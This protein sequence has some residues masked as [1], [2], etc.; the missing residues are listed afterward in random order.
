MLMEISHLTMEERLNLWK[1]RKKNAAGEGQSP[2]AGIISA[3]TT[4]NKAIAKTTPI[5]VPNAKLMRKRNRK[6]INSALSTPQPTTPH[7]QHNNP[8][9]NKNFEIQKRTKKENDDPNFSVEG[10]LCS[11]T[12]P[13]SSDCTEV[14]LIDGGIRDMCLEADAKQ[15]EQQLPSDS[16]TTPPQQTSP[17]LSSSS[18]SH[19]EMQKLREK[20]AELIK[21]VNIA[22]HER[23]EAFKIAKMSVAENAALQ[24]ENDIMNQ[25]V[26][27][28]EMQLS[29]ARMMAFES[30]ED[31]NK[32]KKQNSTIRF[33]RQKNE[34]YE[35]RANTMVTEMTEQMAMLQDMAMKRI[36]VC[37]TT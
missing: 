34:E 4:P 18:V 23:K 1:Q 24:F 21:Q 3:K 37:D 28:L 5:E 10:V 22:N 17:L 14:A 30:Q 6:Y 8:N 13:T 36:Q 15:Q 16:I 29:Q 31:T 12:K 33:L 9:P 19:N 7:P 25:T 11:M 2:R 35:T 26:E 27:D 20:N 32:I